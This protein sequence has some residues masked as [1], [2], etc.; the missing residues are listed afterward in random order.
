MCGEFG[1]SK[2]EEATEEITSAAHRMANGYVG[3]R[4]S[5]IRLDAK[6]F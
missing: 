3:E 6:Q 5:T 2:E 1:K 4:G